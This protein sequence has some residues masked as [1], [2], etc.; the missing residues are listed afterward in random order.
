MFEIKHKG[1]S[2]LAASLNTARLSTTAT[3]SLASVSQLLSV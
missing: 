2:T 1:H 3:L